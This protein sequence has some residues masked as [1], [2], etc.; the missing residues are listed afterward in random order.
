MI[1]SYITSGEIYHLVEQDP[2]QFFGSSC[3]YSPVLATSLLQLDPLTTVYCI[4]F[5]FLVARRAVDKIFCKG[6]FVSFSKIWLGLLAYFFMHSQYGTISGIIVV[7]PEVIFNKMRERGK[8]WSYAGIF[9]ISKFQFLQ[10][11]VDLIPDKRNTDQ[12]V[13][14]GGRWPRKSKLVGGRLEKHSSAIYIG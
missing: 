10:L 6:D 9:K 7:T 5:S 1:P 3:L 4:F 12:L 8:C 2:W 14:R 11:L 13:K